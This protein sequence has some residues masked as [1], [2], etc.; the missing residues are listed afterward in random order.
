MKPNALWET[1]GCSVVGASHKKRGTENQDSIHFGVSPAFVAVSDGHGAKKYIR[2]AIGSRLAVESIKKTLYENLP[3]NT[4]MKDINN[5]IRHIKSRFL[6]NWQRQVDENLQILPFTQTEMDFLQL[7]CNQ[8][9]NKDLE[10]NPRIAFGCTFLCAIAYSDLILIL[11]HGDGDVIGLY[12]DKATDLIR[13]DIRNFAGNTLSLGSLSDA[14]EI[15]HTILTDAEIPSLIM[16]CT[17]G[18]RNSYNDTVPHEI[19]QFYKI[20]VAIKNALLNDKNILSDLENL[21]TKITTNGSGDD[22]TLGAIYN[23]ELLL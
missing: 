14:S 23:S 1:I 12:N 2:S 22:V 21:L 15:G 8:K 5:A 18:I 10:E 17:D 4:S 9:D 20:P 16:L 11:Y 13:T 6:F 7:N 3:L 19:E